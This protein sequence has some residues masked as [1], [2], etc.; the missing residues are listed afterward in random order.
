MARVNWSTLSKRWNQ[1]VTLLITLH[2]GLVLFN[3]SYVPLRGL[4][5]PY[6]PA[7]VQAYDPLKGIEPHPQ[8]QHYL[9][10]VNTLQQTLAVKG[11]EDQQSEALLADLRQQSMTLIEENPFLIENQMA[12]FAQLKRRMRGYMQTASTQDA[13][14]RFWSQAYLADVGWP[15]AFDYFERRI[16]PILVRNYFRQTIATGQFV[17][18]F[19]WV[20]GFF[21]AFFA[22]ELMLRAFTVSR[23]QPSISWLDAIARRWYELPLILPFWRWLRILPMLVRLHR[24]GLV[25]VERLISQITH[26]PAAYLSNRISQYVLVSLI[27]QTQDSVQQGTLFTADKTALQV[28]VGEPDKVNRILDRLTELVIYRVVPTLQPDLEA[29][30]RHSLKQ[31]LTN[32]DLYDGLRQ[33]PGI[34]TMPASALDLLAS[35]L[36]QATCDILVDSYD[37]EQGRVLLEQLNRDF[38]EAL[39]A[40]I[41]GQGTATEL[42]QLL[43]DLLEEVKVNYVKRE[44]NHDPEATLAEVDTLQQTSSS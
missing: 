1:G 4:Y 13:F 2:V 11:L 22:A 39:G 8:T 31:A 36:A 3:L 42:K 19:W 32:S 34:A 9:Q 27:N 18:F 7:L 15:T 41:Q 10:T 23:R 12:A 44:K 37:D 33:I 5:L 29:V 30:L 26:E 24:S 14:Q 25:N 38:R 43:S 28:P 21:M 6:L 20:D 40:E 16:E 17:D 35:Y